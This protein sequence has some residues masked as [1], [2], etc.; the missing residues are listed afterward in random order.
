MQVLDGPEE[1]AR[2]ST[3]GLDYR[4]SI[5]DKPLTHRSCGTNI[6]RILCPPTAE[7]RPRLYVQM[8]RPPDPPTPAPILNECQVNHG[9]KQE[10][11]RDSELNGRQDP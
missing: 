6:A 11:S 9:C 10:A 4:R 7:A 1:K 5:F 3:T 8:C 2:E